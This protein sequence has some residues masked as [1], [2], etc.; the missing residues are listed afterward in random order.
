MFHEIYE[1]FRRREDWLRWMEQNP[2]LPNQDYIRSLAEAIRRHGL[3]DPHLGL[4]PSNEVTISGTNYRETITAKGLNSRLRAVLLHIIDLALE[5][6]RDCKIYAPEAISSLATRLQASFP[7][8]V[9][10]EYLP[11]DAAKAK[12]PDI[13]HQDVQ[14]LSYEDCAFDAYVSCEVFEH[15]PSIK[16][17][18]SEAFRILVPQGK[19]I[20][21]FPF[22]YMH[23]T[24]YQKAHLVGDQ[25]VLVELPEY[26]GNPIDSKGSLVFTIPGWDILDIFRSTGFSD[27]YFVFISSRKHGIVGAEIAGTFVLVAHR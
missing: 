13:Q 12:F 3:V 9:G 27:A 19:L 8:F 2:W 5:R 6:G 1:I 24:G 15:V 11:G 18:I 17:T 16:K 26:H 14:N 20:A 22:R 25:L 4:V 21:T 23:S 7:N 10:S